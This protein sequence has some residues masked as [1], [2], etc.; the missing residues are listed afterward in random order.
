MKAWCQNRIKFAFYSITPHPSISFF[1]TSHACKKERK[2]CLCPIFGMNNWKY[3]TTLLSG[4]GLN[5]FNLVKKHHDY[6]CLTCKV[7]AYAWI[8]VQE[9]KNKHGSKMA[10]GK[11]NVLA[12]P[13]QSCQ[14]QGPPPLLLPSDSVA[15]ESSSASSGLT[16]LCYKKIRL[17]FS[18]VWLISFHTLDL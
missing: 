3:P 1:Q 6:V 12:A 11:L 8:S 14:E 4:P 9:W 7:I 2:Q 17:P 18:S 16:W 15:P 10:N 5:V 13:R